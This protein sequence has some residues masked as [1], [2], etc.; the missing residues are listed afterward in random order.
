MSDLPWDDQRLQALQFKPWWWFGEPADFWVTHHQ[1]VAE[2]IEKYQPQRLRRGQR[3]GDPLSAEAKASESI[4]ITIDPDQWGGM[5]CPHLHF[6]KEIY[7]LTDDQWQ[8][9]SQGVIKKFG[10]R[11]S[12]AK[13]VNFQQLLE[14]SEGIGN[15]PVL[16]QHM[17]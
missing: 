15:L 8:E 17:V 7:L 1:L 5:R 3:G 2:A 16:S 10:E 14:L 12:R 9:F 4:N 11:L 13:T 6:G